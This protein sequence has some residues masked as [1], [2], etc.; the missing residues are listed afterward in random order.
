MVNNSINFDLDSLN[1]HWDSVLAEEGFDI[2]KKP[3]RP[4]PLCGGTDRF[5]YTN[6]HNNGTYVCRHC[7]P[8]KG[9]GFVFLQKYLNKSPKEILQLLKEKYGEREMPK[10]TITPKQEPESKAVIPTTQALSYVPGAY[11]SLLNKNGKSCSYKYERLWGW[12]QEDGQRIG[13]IGRL[14]TKDSHQIFW[15]E[16]G[17]TQG[18]LGDNRP[19]FGL[20][21][22]P[23]NDLV[24]VVEGEKTWQAV[25][26]SIF[27]AACITWTGGAMAVMKSDWNVLKGKRL[28]LCPDNDT[29]G[30]QAMSK[31]ENLLKPFCEINTFK[32]PEGLPKGWDLA[33]HDGKGLESFIKENLITEEVLLGNKQ[34]LFDYIKPLGFDH[35]KLYFMPSGKYQVLDFSGVELTKPVLR[36]LAP[37]HLW[38]NTFAKD[39]GGTDWE[40][41]AEWIIEISEKQK[42]Y[43]SANIRGNGI[44]RDNENHQTGDC[45][46]V[47]H[48]GDSLLINGEGKKLN[49]YKSKYIYAQRKRK[50][51]LPA[52][53]LDNKE[54][55]LLADIAQSFKW[56]EPEAG[57]MI[58]GWLVNSIMSAFLHWRPNIWIIGAP[59]V[60][61]STILDKFLLPCLDGICIKPEGDTTEAGLRNWIGSDSLPVLFDEPEGD[62]ELSTRKM[63]SII[64]F[65]RSNTS[66]SGGM[67]AKGTSNQD[68]QRFQAQSMFCLSS[69]NTIVLPKQDRDRITRMEVLANSGGYPTIEKLIGNLPL[70]VNEKLYHFVATNVKAINNINM[71]F[72]KYFSERF[73]NRRIGDQYGI[74]SSGLYILT[75]NLTV[76][77]EDYIDNFFASNEYLW[78][79]IEKPEDSDATKDFLNFTRDIIIHY[80]TEDGRRKEFKLNSLIAIANGKY[81]EYI[82]SGE[83]ISALSNRGIYLKLEA[84]DYLNYLHFTINH[85]EL[86]E[87][88]KKEPMYQDYSNL[89]LR[90]EGAKSGRPRIDGQ[91]LRTIYLPVKN[92]IED[93]DK[94]PF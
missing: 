16:N 56:R 78:D 80:Q 35:K 76:P 67:I 5:S 61:K 36:Y 86:K 4:C 37:T 43:D 9:T 58:L 81:S 63:Q 92:F 65:L 17:W 22:L 64:K 29:Q 28:I 85:A 42:V 91:Q 20:H 69:I 60:G 72:V 31:I 71:A 55:F 12:L 90:L 57:T 40:A 44:W 34:F 19:L 23:D 51:Q 15:T 11:V 94:D 49:Q 21:T 1:G 70:D 45:D 7:T 88:F 24:Y 53:S 93:V 8:E 3:N 66:S 87:L 77:S 79:L 54:K 38:A 82:T 59:G 75:G 41:A 32:P 14:P 50:I 13:Y 73:G 74:L 18:T 68:G 47:A 2:S 25:V 30:F 33:D 39:E 52:I 10:P 46:V 83:A 27:G 62:S 26:D 84:Q 48:M 89:L 6:T